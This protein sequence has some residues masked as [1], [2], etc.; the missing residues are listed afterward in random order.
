MAKV[1]VKMPDEFLLRLSR[2]GDQID[3]IVP[4]V[5]E[6]GGNVVLEKVRG[7]LRTAIGKDTKY[8]SRTTGELVSSLG[9]SDAKQDRDGN[10]NVKVGFAEPRSDGGSNAKIANIIEYGKH[11]QPAKPFLKPARTA[12]RKPCT[13]AM[14]AKLE[15]EIGKI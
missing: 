3:V 6:A 7:N 14:I 2:L 12:S 4:R 13:D 1:N 8:P 10:Y 11:G 9:L 5:L 15:E